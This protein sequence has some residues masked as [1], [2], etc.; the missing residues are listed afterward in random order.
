MIACKQKPRWVVKAYKKLLIFSCIVAT[1]S[2]WTTAANA[3]VDITL[4]ADDRISIAGRSSGKFFFGEADL[5]G[6]VM[7]V[8]LSGWV[9]INGA[10]NGTGTPNGAGNGTGGQTNAPN[11][12][13][14]GDGVPDG[15]G[16]GTGGVV[17]GGAGNG[18]GD[19]VNAPDGQTNGAGNGTGGRREIVSDW[20][21]AAIA[22]GCNQAVVAILSHSNT[23][24]LVE[25][26]FTTLQT[27]I[28]IE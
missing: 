23:G 3:E 20:G 24:L 26:E 12:G 8:P 13:T 9:R 19:Q 25:E 2:L 16:N 17:P 15:A 18:T 21:V 14:V 6:Q 22:I 5:A 28:C 27:D 4:T 10:G 11:T 1:T 7:V